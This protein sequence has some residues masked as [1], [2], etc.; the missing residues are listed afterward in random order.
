MK[1][2][3]RIPV[4]FFL[5]LTFT[6][7]IAHAQTKYQSIGGVKL[8]I[9]GTSNVHDWD[10]KSDQGYCSSLFHVTNAGAL[11]GV[12]YINFTVPA[13]SLKSFNT[14]MDKNAYKALNT[15]KYSSISFTASSIHIKPHGVSG[16]LLTAKGKLTISGVTK[17]VVVTASGSLKADKSIS[18][19]G[20][21]KLKM[22]D[23]NVDPPA[24]MQGAV[25]SDEVVTVK[26]DLL[27]RSI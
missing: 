12:S 8:V 16:Y 1:T 17:D 15:E 3:S 23:Y 27:L 20:S 26:F 4:F 18:Y 25:K 14:Y 11:H 22:T 10:M 24:I 7:S 6:L 2:S 5:F 9:L 21:F 13:E 19:T